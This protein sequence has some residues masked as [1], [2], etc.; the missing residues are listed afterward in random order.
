MTERMVNVP[1]LFCDHHED[2]EAERFFVRAAGGE[3]IVLDLC[4]Q[5][6]KKLLNGARPQAAVT[7]AGEALEPSTPNGGSRIIDIDQAAAILG[8]SPSALHSAVRR[9]SLKWV[10]AGK[11]GH[12]KSTLR[13]SDVMAYKRSRN[14]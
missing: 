11:K 2:R 8:V 9:G 4:R 6:A 13:R 7:E 3:E 10:A 14:R 5:E 1:K 12:T